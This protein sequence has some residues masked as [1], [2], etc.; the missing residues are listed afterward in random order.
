MG[1][2]EPVIDSLNRYLFDV[3]KYAVEGV[4]E[5]VRKVKLATVGL[6]DIVTARVVMAL[7]AMRD[8]D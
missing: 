4:R 5:V 6:K 7:T 3:W 2:I 8:R 1:A